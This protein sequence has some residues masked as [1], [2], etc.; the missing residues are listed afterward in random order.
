MTDILKNGALTDALGIPYN[1]QSATLNVQGIA[2]NISQYLVSLNPYLLSYAYKQIGF[3]QTAVDAPIDDA[4]RNG[5]EIN[6]QT[7]DEDELNLLLQTMEDNNDWEEI[8]RLG[9]W[10]RLF[11]GAVLIANTEQNISRPL[12]EKSLKGKKLEFISADRWEAIPQD[13]AVYPEESNFLYHGLDVDKSRCHIFKGDESPY[14]V[15]MKLQGWGLSILEKAIPPITQ[16]LKSQNVI[17]EL[18]DEAK[19]DVMKINELATILAQP[20][21]AS[22]ISKRVDIAATQK[23]YK[24]TLIM[25]SLDDYQQK[26]LSMSGIADLSREIRVMIA[27]YLKMPVSKIFG[28]G[29]NGFSS[30]EDERENYNSLVENQVRQQMHHVIKW[31]IDLRCLQLFGRKLPDIKIKWKSLRVM[32]E[33]VEQQIN[34]SKIDNVLKMYDRQLLTPKE[35][36]EILKKS[37]I[38]NIETKAELN[39]E[40]MEMAAPMEDDLLKEGV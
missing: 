28:E 31:V 16:L 11:G 10:G 1:D 32:H 38:V 6:T 9:K 14:Y 15:R 30:G 25:D 21:G 39:D 33:D 4:F 20:N 13:T 5:I 34:T 27:S 29:S 2:Y 8:K 18:L 17:F 24:S 7:L 35:A 22:I 12:S 23:N 37:N 40:Y 36:M 19:I 3:F 26:Q